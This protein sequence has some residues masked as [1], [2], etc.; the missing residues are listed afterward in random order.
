MSAIPHSA[1]TAPPC[2]GIRG[3]Q[4]SS[5]YSVSL[6][7]PVSGVVYSVSALT[8]PVCNGEQIVCFSAPWASCVP[9]KQYRW[10]RTSGE[11][12]K[13]HFFSPVLAILL[14]TIASIMPALHTYNHRQ[15]LLDGLLM[16]LA[17]PMVVDLA[18]DQSISSST[19]S[20]EADS[21]GDADDVKHWVVSSLQHILEN[22]TL[23]PRVALPQTTAVIDLC[24]GI[25]RSEH[26]IV[27]RRYARMDVCT[28]N[29]LVAQLEPADVFHNDSSHEQIAVDRQILI[30]LF[31]FGTY[32]NAASQDKI[33]TISGVGHGTVDLITRRVIT[34]VQESDLRGRHIRW[35]DIQERE[36]AKQWV[37]NQTGVPA[38]RHGWCMV[39]GTT[40]PLYQKPA[41]Y[42]DTFYDRK[43]RYSMNVQLVNTPDR[44]II[45]YS[46]GNRG[47]RHDG[48]CFE[49]TQL[50][51]DHARL[52]TPDEWCWGD[53][54]YKLNKWMMIPY[55]HPNN[56]S[57]E[58]REFN[59]HL[60]C[61]RIRCEHTI[62]YLKGRFQCLRELRIQI[63]NR[64]D[65]VYATSWINSCIALHAFC[66]D[67][68]TMEHSDFLADGL[69]FEQAERE[70]PDD[71][72]ATTR[73]DVGQRA[74]TLQA[75]KDKREDLKRILVDQDK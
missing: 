50:Y 58:N 18:D 54:G 32:G 39:D 74:S 63:N 73:E 48:H 33:A 51:M 36:E 38:W 2:C 14:Y 13:Y 6:V 31:R 21:D 49:S 68:E 28:F 60:S 24:L 34:A 23:L 75:G 1:K 52:L 65:F 46:S 67:H 8:A 5:V 71:S 26:P 37:E 20:S 7:Y 59:Y 15:E 66:L 27:F 11:P 12:E 10:L 30:S 41:W 4:S 72:M 62:G 64:K 56:H 29:Q 61:V 35:P 55:K 44:R 16:S 17:M 70:A 53:Q 9:L 43:Q 19:P 45:D 3:S 22:R 42:G 69:A 25:W 47:S 57:Q 40:I